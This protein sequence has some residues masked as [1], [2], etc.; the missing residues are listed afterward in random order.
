VGPRLGGLVPLGHHAVA[1]DAAIACEQAADLLQCLLLV[2][3]RIPIR[4]VSN[5]HAETTSFER[6][7]GAQNH[8]LTRA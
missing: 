1:S 6:D 8:T 2:T 7:G 4:L 5:G 3:S